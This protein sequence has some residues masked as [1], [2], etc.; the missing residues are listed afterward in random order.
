MSS[1]NGGG[2]NAVSKAVSECF[3]AHGHQCEVKEDLSFICRAAPGAA[4]LFHNSMYKYAPRLF[5]Y[6]FQKSENRSGIMSEGTLARGI[7]DLGRFSLARHI[8]SGGFD[9]VISAHVFGGMMMTAVKKRYGLTARTAII[10]TDH[11]NT[12]GSSEIDMDLHFLPDAS[13]VKKLTGAGI[14][15]KKL[16]V[17]GIPVRRE[18]VSRVPKA[19]AKKRLELDAGRKHILIGGGYMGCGPIPQITGLLLE[20]AGGTAQISVVCAGNER[21]RKKLSAKYSGVPDIHIHGLAADVSLLYDS[22]DVFITKPGG[23][24]TAEAAVK[25]LPM[26]LIHAV[27]GPETH[28]LDFFTSSGCALTGETTEELCGRCMDIL[29]NPELSERMSRS[30]LDIARPGAAETVYR[31]ISALFPSD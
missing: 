27:K 6:C 21:L 30:L 24:S 2:H 11:L 10:E 17:S 14:D 28:N 29:G 4:A 22:A 3:E 19:E 12:P 8:R 9:I 1:R 5:G 7:V 18:I 16:I 13:L 31:E 26:V 25:G 15:E 20:K 23:A